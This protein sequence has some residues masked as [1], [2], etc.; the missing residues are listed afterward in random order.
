VEQQQLLLLTCAQAYR[1]LRQG[2][3]VWVQQQK[4]VTSH[5]PAAAMS[6]GPCQT[7]MER[8]TQQQTLQAGHVHSSSSSRKASR[9]CTRSRSSKQHMVFSKLQ[10]QFR[11]TLT[12]SQARRYQTSQQQQ[13]HWSA[14]ARQQQWA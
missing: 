10:I 12:Q 6:A 5:K 7:L 14:G 2:L 1:A 11:L 3:S 4:Y 9:M 13:G 8:K